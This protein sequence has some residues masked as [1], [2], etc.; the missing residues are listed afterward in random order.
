MLKY[1]TALTCVFILGVVSLSTDTK[2][3]EGYRSEKS[4]EEV[5]GANDAPLN[6]KHIC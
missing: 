3:K 4:K 2:E 5:L 1:L 6:P